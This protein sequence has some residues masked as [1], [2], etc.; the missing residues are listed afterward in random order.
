MAII[1]HKYDLENYEVPLLMGAIWLKD[2]TRSCAN[3][4]R[5]VQY[6]NTII[7]SND[8]TELMVCSA[9]YFIVLDKCLDNTLNE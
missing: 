8:R 3:C 7:N 5:N 9:C 2:A 6:I 1:H 4:E